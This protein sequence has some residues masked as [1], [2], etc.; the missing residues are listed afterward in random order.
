MDCEQSEELKDRQKLVLEIIVMLVKMQDRLRA[1]FNK[2][3]PLGFELSQSIKNALKIFKTIEEGNSFKTY[4]QNQRFQ[5]I[6]RSPIDAMKI[7]HIARM[8]STDE[9]KY[10]IK[11]KKEVKAPED[12]ALCVKIDSHTSNDLIEIKK[13]GQTILAD[14]GSLKSGKNMSI[15]VPAGTSATIEFPVRPQ[16]VNFTG[17]I[18]GNRYGG[19]EEITHESFTPLQDTAQCAAVKVVAMHSSVM[20]IGGDESIWNL[21]YR[22]HGQ[23]N[24]KAQLQKVPAPETMRNFKKV[25]HGKFFQLVLTEEGKLFWHGQSRKYMFGFGGSGTSRHDEFHEIENTYFRY[26]E[27]DKMVDVCGGKNFTIIATE[28]GRIFATSYMFWRQFQECRY[29]QENN[30][31]YP[32]ELKLPEGYKAKQIWGSEKYYN[33]WANGADS[34]GT[35]KTFGAGQHADITGHN[36]TERTS[37]FKPLAVPEGTHMTKITCHGSVAH[38]VDNHNNLWVWGSEI[39]GCNDS[40]DMTNLYSGERTNNSKPMLMKWFKEQTMKVLDVESSD[41]NAIVKV[42]DKE[43]KIA[44]YGLSRSEEKL[45]TI[46]GAA[47]VKSEYKYY[48]NRLEVNADRVEDFAMG[49]SAAYILMAADKQETKSIDP[50]HPEEKGLIHFYQQPGSNDWKF[51]TADQ[52]EQQK[53]SLPDVCFAT[54]QP[55]K[56]FLERVKRIRANQPT[57]EDLADDSLPKLEQFIGELDFDAAAAEHQSKSTNKDESI[58]STSPLYYSFSKISGADLKIYATETEAFSGDQPWDMNPVIFY[59]VKKPAK[60]LE[61]LPLIDLSKHFDQSEESENV[62]VIIMNEKF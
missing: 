5:D 52:Y 16:I 32:F 58:P 25:A 17:W 44:F 14:S 43:G 45:R 54:K 11:F 27:G 35:I 3:I 28:R 6:I 34:D 8:Y 19:M 33:M 12:Q 51:V 23:G 48:I 53:D 60:A 1:E 41:Y 37:S 61:K 39:Y 24:E 47:S 40:D 22:C 38:G 13:E 10:A 50:D 15:V 46:G 29:N 7:K 57:P 62:N 26:E 18:G 30:E 55:I 59:R 56:A 42:S 4:I 49:K 21:G 31:D 2:D 36:S 20:F 9:K